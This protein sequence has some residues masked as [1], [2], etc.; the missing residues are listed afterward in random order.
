MTFERR[1]NMNNNQPNALVTV[2][3]GRDL[4][5][6]EVLAMVQSMYSR[7]PMPIAQRMAM[8]N[9]EGQGQSRQERIKASLKTY[10]VDYGH[11]S[12]A[13]CG[14][15][16][17]FVENL[18]MIASKALEDNALGNYQECSTRYLDFSKQ[19]FY[20]ACGSDSEVLIQEQWR[21]L[22]LEALPFVFEWA[23]RNYSPEKVV[24]AKVAQEDVQAV[25]EKTCKAIAFDVVRNLLPC[26]TATS[27]AW[28]T[29]LRKASDHCRWMMQHPCAEVAIL[30]ADIFQA[31]L[32]RY[33]NS[34]NPEHQITEHRLDAQQDFYDNNWVHNDDLT[35][36]DWRQWDQWILD[37][38][39]TPKNYYRSA[40]DHA[41]SFRIEGTLDFGSYRDLQRHRNGYMGVPMVD[42]RAGFSTWALNILY[43]ASSEVAMKVVAL[44]DKVGSFVLQDVDKQYLYPMGMRVPVN[45]L[46][47][48]GQ[49]KYV[50]GLRSKTSVHPTL[51]RGMYST[52]YSL[53]TRHRASL[54]QG[55]LDS[56]VIDMSEDYAQSDRG[57]QDFKRKPA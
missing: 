45:I 1:L 10:Y 46:W 56:L 13:D 55:F 43:E 39:A 38:D 14:F 11:A 9:D 48:A 19:P 32:Q 8:L 28:T 42:N 41:A 29:S 3:D 20:T 57:N 50:L 37:K 15:I 16:T 17:I 36:T 31:L 52:Y 7:S 12:I 26:G 27:V 44:V 51:R 23:K 33:P 35:V 18:S 40:N 2:M 21:S 22:Y 25:W 5:D 47:N 24:S 6:P 53:T 30:G 54:P 49:V 4:G 34:F